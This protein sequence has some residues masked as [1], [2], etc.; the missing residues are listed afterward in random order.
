VRRWARRWCWWAPASEERKAKAEELAAEHGYTVVPPYDD[1]AIMAGQA[2]CGLEIL[3][4]L[5]F[6]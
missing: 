2:T 3:E 4:Q 1:P 5:G 6:E